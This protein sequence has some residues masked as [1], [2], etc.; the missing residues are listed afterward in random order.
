M[1]KEEYLTLFAPIPHQR[2][3]SLPTQF[4]LKYGADRG[5]ERGNKNVISEHKSIV[6]YQ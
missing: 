6:S 2:Y 4:E 3:K 5:Q 1:G